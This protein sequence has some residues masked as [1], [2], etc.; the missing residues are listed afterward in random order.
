MPFLWTDIGSIKNA[1]QTI[2]DFHDDEDYENDCF[3]VNMSFGYA[4]IDNEIKA[5]C[6][7]LYNEYGVLLVASVSD[8]SGGSTNIVYP[9][10][11]SSV[12]GVGAS[13]KS[14]DQLMSSSNYGNDVEVVAT[15]E[16]ILHLKQWDDDWDTRSGT[17][18]AAPFVSSLCALIL[19][20][21]EGWESSNDAIRSDI[22]NSSDQIYDHSKTF[23]RINAQRAL[24][25]VTPI[26]DE[27]VI[28]GPKIL[29]P[30]S[31]YT[32]NATF[33]HSP[34]MYIAGNW[35]W[36]LQAELVNGYEIWDTGN[37][38]GSSSTSWN[39]NVPTFDTSKNWK[40]DRNGR[41]LAYIIVP[42]T[43][44]VTK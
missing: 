31:S 24:D 35:N 26:L 38:T 6:D 7:D 25:F 32:F 8:I 30:Q 28:S 39:C 41:V 11:H 17:S 40:R 36:K 14:D 43:M 9:A 3:V 21:D 1:L 23:Y 22:I 4:S 33:Y 2:K 12:I 42:F 19:T 20:T 5:L 16:S 13:T 18:M 37:T 27:I 29:N 10:G 34:G 44:A 15:G